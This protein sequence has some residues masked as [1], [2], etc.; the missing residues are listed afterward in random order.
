MRTRRSARTKGFSLIEVLVA[1]G[2]FAIIMVALSGLIVQGLRLRRVNEL[3][4]QAQ[5]YAAAVLERYKSYFT[6]EEFYDDYS[7]E[8]SGQAALDA[9]NTDGIPVPN[10]PGSFDEEEQPATLEIITTCIDVDGS[11]MDQTEC[12]PGN[13]PPLR[14][15]QVRLSRDDR[16]YADLITEV[17]DPTP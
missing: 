16:V 2:I 3:E 15:I 14:R 9:L 8:L 13:P 5:A 12:A 7:S 10:I 1:I 17:G 4:T 6:N 11:D